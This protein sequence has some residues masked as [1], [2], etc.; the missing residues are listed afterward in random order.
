ML[1]H[2]RERR[3][4]WIEHTAGRT[5]TREEEKEW[6]ALWKL[7]VPLKI[8]VFL[9]RISLSTRDMMQYRNMAINSSC[10]ICGM[11]DS[12]RHALLDSNMSK[13]IWALEKKDF[14][15]FLCGIPAQEAKHWLLIIAFE[16]L[17][18]EEVIRIAVALWAVWYASQKTI[19][20]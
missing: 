15:E 10:G 11:W 17:K 18:Q 14:V 9:W 13:L 8:K 1:I 3:T 2:N 7:Q 6:L 4:D 20:E 12:W 19:F 16:S 5:D